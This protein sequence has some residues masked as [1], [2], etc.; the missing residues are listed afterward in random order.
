MVLLV[1]MTVDLMVV[2]LSSLVKPVGSSMCPL[3]M[4][5]IWCETGP[6]APNPPLLPKLGWWLGPL[7]GPPIGNEAGPEFGAGSYDDA[8]L[9]IEAVVKA[10]VRCDMV[11]PRLSVFSMLGFAGALPG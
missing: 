3:N 8:R 1:T 6:P 9:G 5:A 4:P 10:D 2:V 7:N 11:A